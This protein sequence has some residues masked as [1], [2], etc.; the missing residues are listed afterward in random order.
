MENVI[1]KSVVRAASKNLVDKEK[2]RMV[3]L[4]AAGL[5]RGKV[6]AE[7]ADD[8]MKG[9]NEV[10]PIEVENDSLYLLNDVEIMPLNGGEKIRLSGMA[11]SA[12]AIIG[13]FVDNS[14]A[15]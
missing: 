10:T 15:E 12:D 4:T 2:G 5:V 7:E 14:E 11:L 9:I 8:P 13:A 1:F 3:F 6:N